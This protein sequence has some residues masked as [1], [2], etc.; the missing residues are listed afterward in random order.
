L[1]AIDEKG[2]KFDNMV[3]KVHD[4]KVSDPLIAGSTIA[5]KM[6]MDMTMKNGERMNMP[7]LCVYHVENGKIVSE[8]FFV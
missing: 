4:V 2:K 3:E 1:K 7:E 6:E 5:I 8:E